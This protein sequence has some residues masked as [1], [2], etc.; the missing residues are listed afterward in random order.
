MGIDTVQV[1]YL[2]EWSPSVIWGGDVRA[3]NL[4]DATPVSGFGEK[5]CILDVSD[6]SHFYA[7]NNLGRGR[8][9]NWKETGIRN[10]SSLVSDRFR[11]LQGLQNLEPDWIS[12][13]ADKPSNSAI[14]LSQLLLG[15]INQKV[16]TEEIAL[17]PRIVMGPIPSGGIIVEL[18]ADDENAINVVITNDNRVDLEVLFGGRYFEHNIK[19]NEL[20]GMVIS[21]YETLSR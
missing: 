14:F 15:Y 18:H 10:F 21:Q 17:I 16:I 11:Y 6:I 13:G 9:G 3:V 5:P 4:L 2:N 20:L 19:G 7:D 1:P 12:G 8:S